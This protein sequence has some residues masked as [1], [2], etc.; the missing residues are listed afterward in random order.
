ME[1]VK[2]EEQLIQTLVLASAKEDSVVLLAVNVPYLQQT[3]Q[4]DMMKVLALAFVIILLNLLELFVINVI[5]SN[6]LT[7]LLFQVLES[8]FANVFALNLSLDSN[9]KLVD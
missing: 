2:M 6:A 3:A 9:V 4:M 5:K 8:M 1:L 7:V